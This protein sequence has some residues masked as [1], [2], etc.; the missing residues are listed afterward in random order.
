VV[1]RE[2]EDDVFGVLYSHRIVLREC[3]ERFA[4]SYVSMLHV[5][6]WVICPTYICSS[7]SMV[8][9]KGAHEGVSI[10]PPRSIR[11]D[12][13]SFDSACPFCGQEAQEQDGFRFTTTMTSNVLKYVSY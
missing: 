8:L 9:E 5:R 12:P 11:I 1:C 13:P 2:A 10:C 3:R 6:K 7:L 4:R